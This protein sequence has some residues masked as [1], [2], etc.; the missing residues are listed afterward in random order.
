MTNNYVYLIASLPGLLFGMRPPFSFDAFL[1]RC[2]E[3]IPPGDLQELKSVRYAGGYSCTLARNATLRRWV[4][5]DMMIRNELVK[6]RAARRHVDPA[7]YLREDGCPESAYSAHIAINAWRKPTILEA[8]RSLDTDRWAEL[9][10]LAAGHYFDLD[11]LIVYACKLMI[12]EKWE[13]VT[14]ADAGALLEGAL[15]S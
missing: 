13:R 14:S 2:E 5:F 15:V 9:D 12:L 11:A 1:G 4:G 10:E 7:K 6:V 3:F 8:E